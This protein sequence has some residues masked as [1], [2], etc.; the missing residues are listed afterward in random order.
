MW[1][2]CGGSGVVVVV[3]VVPWWAMV[4]PWWRWLCRG[5]DGCVVGSGCAAENEAHRRAR[6]QNLTLL[7]SADETAGSQLAPRGGESHGQP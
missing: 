5:G 7:S 3:V 4:V 6:R 2:L 1:W